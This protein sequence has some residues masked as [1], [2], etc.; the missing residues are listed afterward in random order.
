MYVDASVATS[1]YVDGGAGGADGSQTVS[2]LNLMKIFRLARLARLVRA[3]RFRVFYELKLIVLGV[4]SG[5]RVICW[6]ILLLVVLVYA[7]GVAMRNFVGE[8]E[9]FE[10]VLQAM[11]TCFRCFT[12]GCDS[13]NG[14]PLPERL[15]EHYGG[16]YFVTGYIFVTML[17]NVGV[18]NLI[19]AVFIEN[20]MSSQYVRKQNE[21][22]ETAMA[23]EMKIKDKIIRKLGLRRNSF[24]KS[25]D[26]KSR[27]EDMDWVL[28]AGG[29]SI[30]REEFAFWLQDPDFI[31]LLD[32][33]SIDVSGRVALFDVLDADGGGELSVEELITGLMSL[34]GP[35][36][37]G[38]VPR[39]FC[40]N[41]S[42]SPS[43]SARER[44]RER[45]GA[46]GVPGGPSCPVEEGEGAARAGT[47]RRPR[48]ARLPC[49]GGKAR[50]L[51][52][53]S[54]QETTRPVPTV[55][56]QLARNPAGRSF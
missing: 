28:Q 15:R 55:Q 12:E 1:L 5:L 8:E 13:Y 16:G 17:I 20:V 44:E 9:E 36:T 43:T 2:G 24:R 42:S 21:I 56:L 34:R 18:F 33:A 3:L 29:R 50:C 27:S 41:R 45:W 37:K 39:P 4:F 19:M 26:L 31:R 54:V 52:R 49:R 47:A 51:K 6:A 22:S 25:S 40:E 10:S 53:S 11:F 46:R 48:A 14:T 38:D 23:M 30:S 35:V 7:I 32:E